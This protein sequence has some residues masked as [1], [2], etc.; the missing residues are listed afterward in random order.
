MATVFLA[1]TQRQL[2][3]AVANR[4][5]DAPAAVET[6]WAE[7]QLASFRLAVE[8]QTEI[9]REQQRRRVVEEPEAPVQAHSER[10]SE[11]TPELPA[12]ESDHLPALPEAD[13]AETRREST[14]LITTI[15]DVTKV[16]AGW[17]RPFVPP[18]IAGAIDTTTKPRRS[19]RQVFEETEEIHISFRRSHKVSVQSEEHG[20]EATEPV[21]PRPARASVPSTAERKQMLTEHEERPELPTALASTS[22]HP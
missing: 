21:E 8:A 15:P 5:R 6:L 9:D 10:V 14:S 20:P 12:A 17:L 16:A 18:I 1:D 4:N 3:N 13:A 7:Q 22:S 19:A 2:D 11:P